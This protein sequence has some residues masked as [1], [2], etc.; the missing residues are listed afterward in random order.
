MLFFIC[1]I[2]SERIYHDSNP[3]LYQSNGFNI[4]VG[5][6]IH[7]IKIAKPNITHFEKV[8]YPIAFHVDSLTDLYHNPIYGDYLKFTDGPFAFPDLHQRHNPVFQMVRKIGMTRKDPTKRRVYLGVYTMNNPFQIYVPL[9]H[10]SF[11]LGNLEVQMHVQKPGTPNELNTVLVTPRFRDIQRTRKNR[12]KPWTIDRYAAFW[13]YHTK[14]AF[15]ET[16]LDDE[17]IWKI[18]EIAVDRY[19]SR[20]FNLIENNCRDLAMDIIQDICK[21]EP[22]YKYPIALINKWFYKSLKGIAHALKCLF[23]H[24][25]KQNQYY[26]K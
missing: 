7:T 17:S 11:I 26:N 13:K 22:K 2:L 14:L 1:G 21:N 25:N 24:C 19:L 4:F 20:P 15:C 10:Y 12:E 18:I 16:N 9:F 5:N 6:Q 3:A 23:H 8:Y